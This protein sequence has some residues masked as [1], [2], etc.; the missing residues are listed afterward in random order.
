MSDLL[1]DLQWRY[2]TKKFDSS[3][4]VAQEKVEFTL[5]QFH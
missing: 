5:Y 1:Q 3:K 2:A 4:V